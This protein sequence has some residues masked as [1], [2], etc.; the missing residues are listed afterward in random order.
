MAMLVM[1]PGNPVPPQVYVFGAETWLYNVQQFSPIVQLQ[2][3]L[4]VNGVADTGLIA[5]HV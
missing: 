4:L 1:V 5:M 3:Y 2:P